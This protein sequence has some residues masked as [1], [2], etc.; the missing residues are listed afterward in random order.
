[1]ITMETGTSV[2]RTVASTLMAA[3][4]PALMSAEPVLASPELAK[5]TKGVVS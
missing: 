2:T 5:D 1:M 4:A 3:A